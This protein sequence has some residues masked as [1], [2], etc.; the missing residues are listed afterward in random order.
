MDC[1]V[2]HRCCIH[3]SRLQPRADALIDAL[4]PS[5]R[6]RTTRDPSVAM[7]A[8]SRFAGQPMLPKGMA[9]PTW[10]SSAYY[11]RQLSAWAEERLTTGMGDPASRRDQVEHYRQEAAITSRPL[12]FLAL[13]QLNEL[14][15]EPATSDCPTEVDLALLLRR[16]NQRCGVHPAIQG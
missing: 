9:W 12:Q 1:T 14:P 8:I 15:A 7:K 3:S 10:D 2:R 5:I 11:Q 4:R 6:I 13:I 16:S